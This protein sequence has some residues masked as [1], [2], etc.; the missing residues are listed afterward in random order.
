MVLSMLFATIFGFTIYKRRVEKNKRVWYQILANIISQAILSTEEETL[1]IPDQVKKLLK[2]TM[3]RL[4]TI[5]E[6]IYASKSLS[7]ASIL[8]LKRLYELL[9]LNLDSYKKLQSKSLH[10]KAKGIQELGIMNQR[11]YGKEILRL[12]ND[13]D[14]LVRNEA[15][16]SIISLYGFSGLRF[17]NV[18]T[19]QISQLQ[20]IQ[21]LYKLKGVKPKN[22]ERFK[23]WL[24]SSNDSV[25]VFSLK[26]ARSANC[27]DLYD[28]VINCLQ[29]NCLEI[30]LNALEYMKKVPGENSAGIMVSHYFFNNRVFRLAI[31][32]A[33]KETGSENE[34][35]FLQN[36]LHDQDNEIKAAAAKSLSRLHPLGPAFLQAQSFAGQDPW[37]NIFLEI[38]N[39]YAA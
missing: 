20:Q 31:I 35:S 3:F 16:C 36:L 23:R 24:Q 11:K 25:V 28:D 7:G 17:L 33:L 10:I 5:D 34:I 39:E 27:H 15:Q 30:K 1:E 32:D 26:L 18:T 9:E 13:P 38:K 22:S 8:N 37:K 2:K 14:E 12:T 29:S 4:Y 6:L 21:L 19:R